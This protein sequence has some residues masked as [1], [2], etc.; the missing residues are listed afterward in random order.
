MSQ[1]EFIGVESAQPLSPPQQGLP[2][3]PQ[4]T[5]KKAFTLPADP[6]QKWKPSFRKGGSVPGNSTQVTKTRLPAPTSSI[7]PAVGKQAGV[8]PTRAGPC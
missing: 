8:A 3:T 2:L 6:F 1:R 7:G 5:N 4:K